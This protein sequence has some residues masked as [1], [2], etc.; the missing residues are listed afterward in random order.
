MLLFNMISVKLWA[1]NLNLK[2]LCTAW[3]SEF[4]VSAFSILSNLWTEVKTGK[5]WVKRR[6]KTKKTC[7]KRS[8]IKEVYWDV[9]NNRLFFKLGD[10][11]DNRWVWLV[12]RGRVFL[13]QKNPRETNWQLP[14]FWLVR[15]VCVQGLVYDSIQSKSDLFCFASVFTPPVT[16]FMLLYSAL[17]CKIIARAPGGVKNISSLSWGGVRNRKAPQNQVN[18]SPLSKCQQ[19]NRCMTGPVTKLEVSYILHAMYVFLPTTGAAVHKLLT[20]VEDKSEKYIRWAVKNCFLPQISYINLRW[21]AVKF[22]I[23]TARVSGEPTKSEQFS[24]LSTNSRPI[25][26]SNLAPPACQPLI[27][28]LFLT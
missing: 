8:T 4:V 9:V 15:S 12:I 27:F 18:K 26:G 22:C 7:L 16:N 11:G 19:S 3:K 23:F 17:L 20:R 6:K 14:L 28:P 10:G 1:K 21:N 25:T 5:K 13:D 24:P 2:T